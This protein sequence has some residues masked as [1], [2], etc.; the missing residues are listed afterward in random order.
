MGVTLPKRRTGRRA[1]GTGSVFYSELRGRWIGR[2]PG[3]RPEV[4]GRTQAEVVAKLAA[5]RPPGPRTTVGQWADRWLKSLSVKPATFRSYKKSV[6]HVKRHLGGI[7]LADLTPT[8]VESF[9]ATL[10]KTLHANTVKKVLAELHNMISGAVRDGVIDRNPVAHARKPRRVR[11]RIDPF[12]PGELAAI[13]AACDVP[14]LYPVALL[15]STGCRLGESLALDASDFDRSAGTVAITKT[16]DA[17]VGTGTPK[18]VNSVRTIRVPTAALPA[19]VAAA[20]RRKAGPLFVSAEGNRRTA[21]LVGQSWRRL[22]RRLGLAYRNPHQLRHSVA[23]AMVAAGYSPADVAKYLGDTAQTVA[24]TYLHPSGADP[25]E[26]MDRLLGGGK[27]R[28][29][30][31][32]PTPRHARGG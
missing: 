11:K 9:A 6:A 16:F 2:G 31:E 3:G 24:A 28:E 7:A 29:A 18:S 26:A 25:S 4:W 32:G 10:A 27:G 13:V 30:D 17:D 1:R 22:L 20:G 12:P 14:P 8:R 23:T 19:L 21:D 15:A 5:A